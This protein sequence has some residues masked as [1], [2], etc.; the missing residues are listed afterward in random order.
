[1]SNSSSDDELDRYVKENREF[2]TRLLRYGEEEAQ[3]YALALLA[4]GG[5]DRDVDAVIQELENL[6]NNGE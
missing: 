4:N 6:R 3:G 5:T 1:M 2:L